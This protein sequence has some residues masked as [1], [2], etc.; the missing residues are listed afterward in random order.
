[1]SSAGAILLIVTGLAIMALGLL[2]FYA[3][4]PFLYGFVGFDIGLLLGR[5]LTGD[6]GIIAIILGAIGAVVLAF[7][8]YSL[9]PYRRILLG[10]SA[11]V[12]I[13][14][15][16]AAGCGLSG[17]IGTLIG[18]VLAVVFGLIGGNV[19]PRYFDLFV[20]FASAVSGAGMVM[21]GAHIL[22]PNARIF[23][24]VNGGILPSV[25]AIVL[26]AVAVFWQFSNITKWINYQSDFTHRGPGLSPKG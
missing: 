8:S 17:T 23:D 10:V 9:E 25:L 1:M 21:T 16:L 24:V 20:I 15:A 4:L 19:V 14:L 7:A 5:W 12:L 11:G 2:L 26:A 13:G 3:W 18:G 22:M 6:V